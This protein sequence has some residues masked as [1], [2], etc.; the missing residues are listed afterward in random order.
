[1]TEPQPPGGGEG[2]E[3]VEP[4]VPSYRRISPEELQQLK[5]QAG[6]TRERT[7]E[8]VVRYV[9]AQERRLARIARGREMAV[10]CQAERDALNECVARYASLLRMLGE[11]PERTLILIK[12]AFNEAAP[13]HDEVNRST[14][15]EV[16]AWIIAAYYA[17]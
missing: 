12:G 9:A 1:V 10:E 6:A 4:A 5:A 8:L 13:V 11:P 7:K 15:D 16:V 14:L 3:P 2:D 17:A